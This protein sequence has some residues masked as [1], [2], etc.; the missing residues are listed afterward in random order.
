MLNIAVLAGGLATRLRPITDVIP[1][2][3]IEIH[4]RPFIDWQLRLLSQNGIEKIVICIGY[5]SEMIK[6]FVGNGAKYGVE[7]LYSYD[8]QFQLGTGGAIRKALPLLGDEFMVIYGDSYLP[9]DFGVV[10]AAFHSAKKPALMTV[11]CNDGAYDDSNVLFIDG[12]LKQY[13][14]RAPLQRMSHIDYGLSV[15]SS[16]VFSSF[17]LNLPLDLSQICENL[18]QTGSLAGYEVHE[19]FYEIGSVKGI[20]EFSEYVGRD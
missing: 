11:F 7:I 19:R 5:K 3:L 1:K 20:K 9:T 4:N 6:D 2:S 10:E 16:S 18:S 12:E 17:P 15:F 8:G 13:S 14:K